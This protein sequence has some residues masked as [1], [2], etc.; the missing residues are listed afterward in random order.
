MAEG[1]LLSDP[2]KG[3]GE[4]N[5]VEEL[6]NV[7]PFDGHEEALWALR[8]ERRRPTA[9]HALDLFG[10]VE[11]PQK[12]TGRPGTARRAA[13]LLSCAATTNP[14]LA[15]WTL[16]RDCGLHSTVVPSEAGPK[17]GTGTWEDREHFATEL[18]RARIKTHSEGHKVNQENVA[19]RLHISP[20]QLRAWIK[21]YGLTWGK[22]KRG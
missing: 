17:K 15:Y 16:R 20:R 11:T 6:F 5:G 12:S 13:L 1:Q 3:E 14:R 19:D 9:V 18:E 21:Y 7:V 4:L 22:I 10:L 8:I 2:R